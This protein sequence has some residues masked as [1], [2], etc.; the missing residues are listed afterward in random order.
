MACDSVC[1]GVKML[2]LNHHQQL[3]LRIV[4]CGRR[5]PR[6]LPIPVRETQPPRRLYRLRTAAVMHRTA[7]YM[8]AH[9]QSG[10]NHR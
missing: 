6:R 10:S 3:N 7:M 9:K 2:R 5:D 4:H 1:K 8:R